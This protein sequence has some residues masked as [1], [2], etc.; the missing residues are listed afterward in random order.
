MIYSFYLK[1]C[2]KAKLYYCKKVRQIVILVLQY[3][4]FYDILYANPSNFYSDK[5]TC[6]L[7]LYFS[8]YSFLNI[9]IYFNIKN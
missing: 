3:M 9:F 6:Y 8:F 7:Y 2:L 1:S 4:F 5:I